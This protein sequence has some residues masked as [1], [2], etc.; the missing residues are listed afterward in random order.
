MT[1]KRAFAAQ[2]TIRNLACG[3]AGSAMIAALTMS[4]AARADTAAAPAADAPAADAKAPAGGADIVVTANRRAERGQDVP[5]AI[6]VLSADRLQQQGISKAQDL[7]AS[8]PSLVVGP[9]GQ[10]SRESQSFTLR[11]QGTTF[12]ASPGVVVYMNEV[13][14]ITGVSLSQQ[15]GPGNYVDVQNLQV[16]AGPQGTLFGRN[17]TGG[18]VLIVPNKPTDQFGGWLKAEAGDYARNNFEGAVNIPIVGDKVLLRVAGAYHD[19]RGFTWD[20]TWKKWR[21]DEHWYSGRVGLLIKPVEGVENYTLAYIGNSSTN[22]TGNVNEGFNIPALQ[23]LGLC[24]EGPT[25]PGQVA[26]C[27]VY[28]AAT[29][30]AQALG[31]RTTEGDIDVFHKTN[32]WG[33]SNTTDIKAGPGL[34][35]RNIFSYQKLRLRYRYDG[36]GTVLQQYDNDP[37]VL[38][39][40]GQVTLPGDGTPL[41]YANATAANE[42]D[43]DNL[44]QWTEE[45]QLQGDLLNHKLNFALGGF[46]FDMAPSGV[47]GTHELV[48]C[49]AAFTG[50]CS[51]SSLTYGTTSQSKALYAQGTLD[52]G[53]LTPALDR[54]RLTGG[55]RY[56]WDHL[57]GFATN[58]HPDTANPALFNCGSNGDAGLTLPQALA[59]CS[60]SGDLKT[61]SPSWLIGL[62]YKITPAIMAYGKI[63]RGYKA[64]GFNPYS[65]NPGTETFGP[66]KV[67]SYEIGVK[68]NFRF[69]DMPVMF[70][71]D[72]YTLDYKGIQR[73]TGDVNLTTFTS[74]AKTVNPDARIKGIEI[75]AS[76]RPIRGIQIGGNFSYLDAYYTHYTFTVPFGGVGCNGVV[77]A[78]GTVDAHCLPFQYT[79]PYIFSVHLSAEQSLGA[80]AGKLVFF[81]NYSHSS[82]QYTDATQLPSVQPGAWLAGFGLLNMSLDW[83]GIAGSRLD[84]GLFVTN[85]TNKLYRISNTDVY[86]SGSLLA[87]STSYGEPRMYGVRL[88]YTFGGG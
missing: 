26:S 88:K 54:V 6:T 39:V 71:I 3:I 11:G 51:P 18:A 48:Y 2:Q 82:A 44:H 57:T 74:G 83:K 36:D 52:L 76:I 56:T 24:Y 43:R 77:G 81:S 8:V 80:N 27:N 20:T 61:H 5:I 31:P 60:I 40:P 64:G 7:Q 46:Y 42:Y 70:N 13:P 38:P 73:A 41:T 19:R 79:S 67:T 65:V 34:T 10:G 22:G 62:D 16:L 75:E 49:P 30:Q 78:G 1:G 21:D 33:V 29:A 84:A 14:L 35:V 72:G 68:T 69:G 55:Y 15:G 45:L 50:F 59:Q 63:S 9:N 37:G 32:S 85:A 87:N 53:A 28:R 58:Y 23:G 25:I 86:Q 12:Q 66:E 4:A 47:Q 17:T